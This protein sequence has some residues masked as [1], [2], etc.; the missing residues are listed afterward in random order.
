MASVEL[1]SR[2]AILEQ[3]VARLRTKVEAVGP[4]SI[5]W[6][7]H[8]A[9]TFAN[10]PIHEKAMTLGRE[11]RESLRPAKSKTRKGGRVRP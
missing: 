10:D 11:Y 9:G 3:E 6:W 5:P 1:E 8:I 7:Q 4:A 2:V